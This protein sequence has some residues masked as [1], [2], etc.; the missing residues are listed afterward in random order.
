MIDGG[1]GHGSLSDASLELNLQ[2]V[3]LGEMLVA[4]LTAFLNPLFEGVT[5]E[6]MDDVADIGP[7]HF[8]DLSGDG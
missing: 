5:D 8:P 1:A 2:T 3:L 4:V 6:G 7:W